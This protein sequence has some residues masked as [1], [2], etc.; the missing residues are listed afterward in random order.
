MAAISRR[1]A[2]DQPRCFLTSNS[3]GRQ[4]GRPRWLSTKA[5]PRPRPTTSSALITIARS[6]SL[7]P[8]ARRPS[9]FLT[10]LFLFFL[11]FSFLLFFSSYLTSLLSLFSLDPSKRCTLLVFFLRPRRTILKRHQWR[12]TILHALPATCPPTP[13]SRKPTGGDYRTRTQ[14]HRRTEARTAHPPRP[15][16]YTRLSLLAQA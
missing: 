3:P 6:G 16:T 12:V 7:G 15:V 14:T 4:A 9:Y 13:S 11:F 10:T 5:C 2:D 8:P 1:E